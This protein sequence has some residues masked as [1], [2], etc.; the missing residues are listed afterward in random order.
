MLEQAKEAGAMAL[1]GEKYDDEVRVVSMGEFSVELCGGIHVERTGD[2][3]LFKITSEGGIA[4]GVRRIEAVTGE[5]ALAEVNSLEANLATIAGLL[6][7]DSASVIEKVKAALD[8]NKSLEKSLQ[9]LNDKLS[10]QASADLASQAKEVNGVKVLV[11][12]ISGVEAKALRNTVDELKQKLGSAIIALGLKGEGKVNLIVG[13]TQ[14]LTKTVKAGELVNF[15]A[16]Q[17]GGKGGGR[18]DLAQ[19]GGSQPENL[20]SAIASVDKW[21]EEKL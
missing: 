3:G 12:E 11:A 6:K 18:P 14:D 5:I 15:L 19:A 17:V 16:Q 4:A 2:I 8:K 20:A 21:L 7:T 9:Q 1:F 10:S 13:V